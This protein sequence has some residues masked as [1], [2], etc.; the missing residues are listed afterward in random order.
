MTLPVCF[1]ESN[2]LWFVFCLS[3]GLK[4]FLPL[5]LSQCQIHLTTRLPWHDTLVLFYI[6]HLLQKICWDTTRCNSKTTA[7]PPEILLPLT[8]NS[9]ASLTDS[10]PNI[11]RNVDA[12]SFS[13]S[14]TNRDIFR[15]YS[16]TLRELPCLSI[17]LCF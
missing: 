14:L 8:K 13:V 6:L 15:K 11:S 2:R 1:K 4:K 9:C 7:F 5:C 17:A 12:C 16:D 10:L 3:C